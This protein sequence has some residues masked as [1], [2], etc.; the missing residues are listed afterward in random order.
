MLKTNL[1][2]IRSAK[3]LEIYIEQQILVELKDVVGPLTPDTIH[4]A[5][6]SMFFRL[7]HQS[8]IPPSFTVEIGQ[9]KEVVIC[10]HDANFL[11]KIAHI[12]GTSTETS[13]SE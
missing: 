1:S 5:L 2:D 12:T 10:S 3:D 11:K 6:M 4:H 8:T 13:P 9:N 7:R